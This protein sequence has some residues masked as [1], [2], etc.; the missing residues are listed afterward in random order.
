M[1]YTEYRKP[2]SRKYAVRLNGYPSLKYADKIATDLPPI[3]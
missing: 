2:P 3:L 1:V